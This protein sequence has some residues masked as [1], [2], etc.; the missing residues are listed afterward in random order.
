M[1]L[2][3]DIKTFDILFPWNKMSLNR[4]ENVKQLLIT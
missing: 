4:Q 2:Q 1:N 3:T